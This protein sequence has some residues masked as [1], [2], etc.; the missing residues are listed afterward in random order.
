M[1]TLEKVS[2]NKEKEVKDAKNQLRQEKKAAVHEYHDFNALLE[3]LGT[4][5]ADEFD[6]VVRQAKKAYPNLDFS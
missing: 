3:E 2:A 1:E 5:Y 4:S 6:D